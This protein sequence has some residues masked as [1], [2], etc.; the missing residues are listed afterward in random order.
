LTSAAGEEARNGNARW[1]EGEDIGDSDVVDDTPDY[2]MEKYHAIRACLEEMSCTSCMDQA[3][4]DND[5]EGK[6]IHDD[7]QGE[8][9]EFNL[10]E[11]YTVQTHKLLVR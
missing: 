9:C 1:L 2:I 4:F 6:M 8:A 3:F 7:E 10:G 11:G 5:G